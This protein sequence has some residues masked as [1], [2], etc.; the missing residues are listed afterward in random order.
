MARIVLVFRVMYW[1]FRLVFAIVAA[2]ATYAGA[3]RAPATTITVTTNDNYTKIESAQSGDDVL[4]SP[5]TY[6]FRVYLTRAATNTITIEGEELRLIVTPNRRVQTRF[7]AY[8]LQET[9]GVPAV[10]HWHPRQQQSSCL[11]THHLQTVL[12][13]LD[14]PNAIWSSCLHRF[15][16]EQQPNF[17]VK[18]SQFRGGHWRKP[19]VFPCSAN[20]C[21]V[22]GITQRDG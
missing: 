12:A 9:L 10:F 19:H 3:L 13:D 17:Q 1:R 7:D 21:V 18:M 4:I 14:C 15:R 6:G 20:G 2:L 11:A 5:G 16:R 8:L 22:Q